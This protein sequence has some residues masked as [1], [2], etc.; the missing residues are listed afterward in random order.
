MKKQ[1]IVIIGGGLSGLTLAYLLEKKNY[2]ITLIEASPRLG[3]RIETAVG[4]LGTPLELG[5]TWFSET[6]V[7]LLSLLAKLEIKKYEQYTKGVS[8]F[9]TTKFEPPQ[10]FS[11]PEAENP[12]LE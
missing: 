2:E 9:Q 7:Q 10:L 12:H 3:G 4:N 5:A 11:V 8:L 6:H 1:R